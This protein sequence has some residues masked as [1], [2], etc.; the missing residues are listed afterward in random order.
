MVDVLQKW[1]VMSLSVAL[2][3]LVELTKLFPSNKAFVAMTHSTDCTFGAIEFNVVGPFK[4]K[5]YFV[6]I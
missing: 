5:I 4:Y 6:F 3:L 2:P 1:G